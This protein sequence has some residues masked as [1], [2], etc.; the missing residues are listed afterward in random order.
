MFMKLNSTC[1]AS[2]I[3]IAKRQLA[4]RPIN[5]HH[6]SFDEILKCTTHDIFGKELEATRKKLYDDW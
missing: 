5:K 3:S 1:N 2:G 4:I 6:D